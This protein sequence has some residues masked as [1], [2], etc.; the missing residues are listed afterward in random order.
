MI[1]GVMLLWVQSPTT[2]TWRKL[3]PDTS[4]LHEYMR[5]LSP[6]R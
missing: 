3:S 1:H 4:E 2:A 6:G 5:K